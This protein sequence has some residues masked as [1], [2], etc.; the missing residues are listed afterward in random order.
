MLV[1]CND[2]DANPKSQE[3]RLLTASPWSHAL[4][5]HPTDGDLSDQ[6]ETFAI[7]FSKNVEDGYDGT[8]IISNGGYAFPE[9]TGKWRFNDSF[10]QIIL[11]SGRELNYQ[12]DESTLQLDFNVDAPG[13]RISGLS[14]HFVFDLTPL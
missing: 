7:S 14:G 11:D 12:L 9:N 4:V 10:D 5:T 13:G 1:S 2:D 3:L 6:Y 8:F